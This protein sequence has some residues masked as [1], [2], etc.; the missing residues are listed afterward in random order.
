M[1]I[2]GRALVIEFTTPLADATKSLVVNNPNDTLDAEGIKMA[3]EAIV[4]TGVFGIP[5]GN[6]AVTG[7]KGAYYSIQQEQ[8]LPLV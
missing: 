7:V 1:K 6:M 5:E 8:E 3:A 4:A 2:T